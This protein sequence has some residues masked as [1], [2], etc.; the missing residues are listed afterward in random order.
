MGTSVEDVATS[1]PGLSFV[2]FPSAVL[3]MPAPQVWAILFFFMVSFKRFY[4]K[5]KTNFYNPKIC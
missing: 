3:L 5:G 1:G 2:A 4:Q